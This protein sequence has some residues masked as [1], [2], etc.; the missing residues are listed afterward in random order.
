[1]STKKFLLIQRSTPG[2]AQRPSPAQMQEMYAA[3]SAWKE[4]F[5]ENILDMGGKLAS[6][7]KVVTA[8]RVMD[9]P[10]VETKEIIGGY[11]LVAAENYEQAIEV[12]RE[13]PGVLSPGSSIEIREISDS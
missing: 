2:N 7:G 4:K 13:C 10:L 3:F 8:S 6:G 5:K 11:M 1:M 9:G 12:A